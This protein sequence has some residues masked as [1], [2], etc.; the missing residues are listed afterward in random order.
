[1]DTQALRDNFLISGIM[2]KD[3]INWIYTHY[4]RAM[5]GGVMPA[6]A[7]VHLTAPSELKADTFLAR[8]EMGVINVSGAGIPLVS[9]APIRMI[10]RDFILCQPPLT[11]HIH[12]N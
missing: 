10:L 4:D 1:M 6:H 2:S 11:M 12:P 8:R 9:K 5:V 7:P 3:E